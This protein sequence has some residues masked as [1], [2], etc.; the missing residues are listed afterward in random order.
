MT[1]FV[2]VPA[3]T[4]LL[5]RRG[6]AA[7]MAELSEALREDFLRWEDFDKSARVAS[8]SAQG[9]IELMPVADAHRYAFKY[10][11]GHPVNTSRGMYT[12][13]AFGVLADVASGYPLLLSELTLTTA[14]RTAA[15]SAMA[16]KALARPDSR[17]MALIGNGAQSEFQAL[18]FHTQL[19]IS[20]IVAYDI[21]PAATAKLERNLAAFPALKVRRAGSVAEAVRG[22]DIVTT[23]TADKTRATIISPEMIEPGMH[24]NG[25]GGDCPGKTELHADVLRAA[26]IFVEYEPQTR[27]EGDIQ[28]L[29]ADHPVVDLWRVL[30]GSAEG[31]QSREQVTVFDSV[32]FALEDYTALRLVY[33][34][35]QE[36]GIG[37]EVELV[38]PA[39]DPKDLFRHTR[40]G[41]AQLRRAA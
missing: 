41:R 26:R 16:A 9:V 15:T 27:I 30:A 34:L 20:E 1:R 10:V 40:G 5:Q 7:L 2:D 23:V 4:Q 37:Q 28:Q 12:V 18:A 33:R 32:G 17:R 24:I 25:V 8:H 39:D 21:D 31:R 3:L 13:M 22:A 35:A 6:V 19:G 11:N 36:F 29:P 14:L 38:P